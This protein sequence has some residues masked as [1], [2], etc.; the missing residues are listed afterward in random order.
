MGT[1]G[2]YHP[3]QDDDFF[4]KSREGVF[5]KNTYTPEII[6]IALY[7][8]GYKVFSRIERHLRLTPS[9]EKTSSL[10]LSVA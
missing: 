4:R 2:V 10:A 1:G 5:S 3:H 6:F 7:R 8:E 9:T